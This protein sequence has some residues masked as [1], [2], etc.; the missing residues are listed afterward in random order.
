MIGVPSDVGCLILLETVTHIE[1][2]LKANLWSLHL[3]ESQL[4]YQA[5]VES[6][7]TPITVKL[8]LFHRG[9]QKKHDIG[10]TSRVLIRRKQVLAV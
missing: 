5:G 2:D 6:Q 10:T 1:Q 8:S 7:A 9:C 3:D 4:R